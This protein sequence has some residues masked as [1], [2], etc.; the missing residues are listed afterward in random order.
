[1]K[2]EF[3]TALIEVRSMDTEDKDKKILGM[4]RA[5]KNSEPVSKRKKLEYKKEDR[6]KYFEQLGPEKVLKVKEMMDDSN[7]SIE[8]KSWMIPH[9]LGFDF[10]ISDN[11][12]DK[13]GKMIKSFELK[14][15]ELDCVIM[16]YADDI[17]VKIFNFFQVMLNHN[18]FPY[19]FKF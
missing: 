5:L 17:Y 19:D 9:V 13:Y 18:I 10:E 4:Y 3:E 8:E 15:S 14:N 12:E 11:S 6:H 7:K 1:M 2:H 16:G